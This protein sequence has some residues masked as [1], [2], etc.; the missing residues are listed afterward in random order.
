ME[1]SEQSQSG[2]GREIF[3]RDQR[4]NSGRLLYLEPVEQESGTGP[5]SETLLDQWY[6]IRSHMR[7]ILTT[8]VL[9][10]AVGLLLTLRQTPIY[11]ARTSLELQGVNES[12][13][14]I[15]IG[16][17]DNG[18]AIFSPETYVQTQVRILNSASLRQRVIAKLKKENPGRIY[19]ELDLLSSWRKALGLKVKGSQHRVRNGLPP[20]SLQVRVLPS[21]RVLD[22]ICDSPDAVFASDFSNA[23]ANE[24]IEANLEARWDAAQRTTFWLTRQIEEL[25]TTLKVSEDQLQAY[26]RKA[27]LIFSTDKES[28]DQAK[29]KQLQEEVSRAQADRIAKQSAYEIAHAAAAESVP[30]VIDNDRL[31]E[32]QAKLAELRRE[33]AELRSQLTPAHYR[34]KRVEAQITQLESTLVKERESILARIRNEYDAA[35]R[36]EKLMMGAFNTQTALVSEEAVRSVTYNLLKREVEANR[37]L[38]DALLQKVKEA[39]I[40]SALR[41]STGRVIDPAVPAQWPYKPNTFRNAAFGLVSGLLLGGAFVMGKNWTDRSVRAPGESARHLMVPELGVIPEVVLRWP[42]KDRSHRHPLQLTDAKGSGK[43]YQPSEMVELVSWQNKPS[44]ISESFRSVLTSMMAST[45][46]SS[47]RVILVT[48]AGRGEGKSMTVSN[49]GIALAEIGQRVLLVDADM[50]KPRLNQIFNL[51]NSWGLSDLLRERN[52]IAD[53]PLEALVRDTEIAGLRVLPSGPGTVSIS[54][55][56]YSKRME[57]LM[58]RFRKEF[59]AILIDTPPMLYISDARVLAPLADAAILV[60]RSGKTTRDVALAVKQCM[61]GDGVPLLGTI[62]NGWDGKTRHRDT[63][64]YGYYYGYTPTAK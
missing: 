29:L 2:A 49:L 8:A 5:S 41:A 53:S 39:G 47:V 42:S 36:R 50:R 60:I 18:S 25:R 32:Y 21:T 43:E 27:G 1:Q 55:L 12:M 28:A 13:L 52:S 33:L 16:Q 3:V 31:S 37:S 9:M 57:D 63:Y 59:D 56:L 6:L 51:S 15:G 4:T 7:L 14:N 62:L 22:I 20:L 40:V 35:L 38:Y 24:Y 26:S 23:L 30:Q 54:N 58:R 34:V 46:K 45:K 44:P 10:G 61:I 11:Q 64:G 17:V 48:S 19:Y